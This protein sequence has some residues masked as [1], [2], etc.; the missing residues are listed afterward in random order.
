MIPLTN[1]HFVEAQ[2][3]F[4]TPDCL[5]KVI[6]ADLTGLPAVL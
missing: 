3:L 2:R 4:G 6:A 5:L 1:F